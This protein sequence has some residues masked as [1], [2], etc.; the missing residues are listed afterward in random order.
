MRLVGSGKAFAVA[1][2]ATPALVE[3]VERI[4]AL[5]ASRDRLLWASSAEGAAAE[6]AIPE[7]V[8]VVE[9]DVALGLAVFRLVNRAPN[10]EAV[11]SIAEA[12][13]VAGPARLQ[14]VAQR[15]AVAD[16][17]GQEPGEQAL[18]HFRLHCLAV[19]SA[20]DRLAPAV[21]HVDRDE[22][23]TAALLHDI[24]K[25]ALNAVDAPGTDEPGLSALVP[26]ADS[27]E[28]RIAAE[29]SRFGTDHAELGGELALHMGFPDRLVTAIADHHSAREGSAG[30]VRLADMLALYAQGRVVDINRLVAVSAGAGLG[31][32]ALGHLMY[33]LPQPA[34][35]TTRRS[36]QPC[37]LS[38]R[39]IEV[40]EHLAEG[41]VYKQIGAQLGLS[42][43]TVRS[44]LHR[45][46][47]RLGAVDRAQAVL[48]ARE[49]GWL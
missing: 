10:R 12:V 18:E 14:A 16:P 32:K 17:L 7:L 22:M 31:R 25:L 45:I 8:R 13:P 1:S 24:G 6:G 35:A 11:A 21:G 30:L 26:S 42:P 39:E 20:M 29:R 19:Q 44:H 23:L 4:P 43:S 47:H 33:E 49:R 37:P 28:A 3:M 5:T 27:P 40:L 2:R 9:S 41:Q 46:Y 48:L 38:D 15:I 36:L 34:P